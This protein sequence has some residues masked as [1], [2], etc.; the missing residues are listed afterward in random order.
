MKQLFKTLTILCIIISSAVASET[1]SASIFSFYNGVALEKSEVLLD[2]KYSYYTDEDGSVELILETGEHQIEIFAKDENGQ[3]LGYVKKTI[4]IKDSRDTQVIA[5]FKEENLTPYVEVD[6]PVGVLASDITDTTNTAIFHGMVRTSDKNLP[7]ANARVFVKGTSIDAKTDENGN[8]YVE[9]PA[10]TPISLSIVHSEYSA[11]TINDITL[12]KDQTINQEIKLTPASMELEEFIVLAP[13]VEG[14]ISA[15]I[16]EAKNSN[17]I[18]NIIGSEQMSKQGDSNAA[19]ALKRVAG[20]TI[21]GGK[22]VYVRGLG[23]RYSA[24]E[25]N[26]LSLPSPN[27][28]KR[29][30][31][32][33]MFPSGVIGSLQVQKTASADVT[34]AFGGGYVNIRTKEKFDED[35]AKLKLG[36]EVH[37]SFGQDVITSQGGSTDFFG[38]DD[39]Y[40]AFDSSFIDSITPKIGEIKPS[41]NKTDAQMQELIT[42]RSYNHVNTTVPLGANI[43]MQFAKKI[44]LNGDHKVYVSGDYGYKTKY[45]NI[46]YTEYDYIL[47]STGVQSDD[48][49][50]IAD[51]ARYV[52]SIQ[53]GGILNLGYSYRSLDLKF[54]KL[55]V[56]NTLNQS[57]FSEGTFGENNSNEQQTYFEWQER[58]LDSNQFTGG[59]DY[60]IAIPNRFD[61]GLE[62]A[63][64]NEYVPNDIYY[65]Y[66]KSTIPGSEYE[67]TR[68]QSLLTFLNRTTEDVVMNYYVKNRTDI[69]LLSDKDFFE[70]GFT[71]EIKD[72]VSRVNRIQMQSK[73]SDTDITTGPIDGVINTQ[74]PDTDLNFD[75]GSQPKESFDGSLDRTAYYFNT[76][77]KPTQDMDI[78]FGI[79]HVDLTETIYQFQTVD[80]I[81]TSVENSLSFQKT[82][83]SM[84]L[85]YA[86]N[87]SNQLKFAYSETFIYPDF[88]EFSNT[89][90]IHPVF[91]AKVA[92]N[93]DLIETDIQSYDLQYGYYFNDTDNITASLFYKHM[94]NPIEDVREFTTSTLDKFSFENSEQADLSG[95]EL[96]WYK[97]LGFISDYADNFTFFGNY[98]YIESAVTLTEEQKAKYV[99]T[100]RGLQGLSPEVINLALSY[101]DKE[102]SLNIS[103]NKM[104]ERLMRVALK[105]GTTILGLDDYETPPDLVD[106]TWIEKFQWKSIGTDIDMTFKIKNLLD[107][108]TVW[109]QGSKVSLQYKEG[110]SYSLSFSA[111]I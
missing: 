65:N 60:K 29:T 93:P 4:E 59:F 110:T 96:S 103:Y 104:S 21:I 70:I 56:L 14:S 15:L 19:S 33:D 107:S 105:N 100:E 11:Q 82:L 74:Y 30:V 84:T 58:E 63:T 6:T 72:R 73:I 76:L 66:L 16:A 26:G 3:S 31:P 106:F 101:Q 41:L 42:Q 108:E 75:L 34:G 92:G 55:Y 47:S 45:K 10:D 77:I 27:P 18:S 64:A 111:K 88:R 102:R 80:N 1:G 17:S 43:E 78:T 40:R 62:Y 71:S 85:K 69:P 5:T 95:I 53:H 57:R 22:Y 99:T 37:S 89:E 52:N 28:I 38:I 51:T 46:N 61:F 79:R 24:T 13:R 48:P 97:N 39:G 2:G 49:D 94:K 23:D 87:K 25:L 90:F 67:F 44:K 109:R 32:L 8:F 68:N 83:P 36:I 12:K 50:N 91:I 98:T 7:I 86:F 81:V 9:V 20:V 35:Y 54:S